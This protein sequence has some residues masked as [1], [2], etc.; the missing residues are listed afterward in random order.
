MARRGRSSP[1]ARYQWAARGFVLPAVLIMLVLT[2]APFVYTT[3]ISF[4]KYNGLGQPKWVGLKNYVSMLK[5]PHIVS[6]TLNTGMWVLGTLLVPVAL[7]L[8]LALLTHGIKGGSWL[9][10]PFLVP[11]AVSGATVA[12]VWAFILQPGGA[13]NEALAW[14]HLPGASTRWLL[15]APLSTAMMILAYAWQATGV[16]MLLF[17]VGLQSIPPEPLEAARLDGASGLRLFGHILW[18][19]LR[20]LTTVVVG[21]AIVGSLKTFDIVWIMTQGGPGRSS[22]TLAITMYR[23][24]FVSSDYGTGAA[25]AL[26]LTVVTLAASVLYIRRQ[27]APSRDF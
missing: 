17:V 23:E 10:L 15:A 27:L 8:V 26:A 19:M 20:P 6:S 16:N 2:Y 25:V 13:L 18:P 3:Y 4:T 21:L 1:D 7:G 11:Y 24:T 9:R 14:L 22:E 5:D 12:V